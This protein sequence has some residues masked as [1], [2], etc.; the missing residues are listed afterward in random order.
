MRKQKKTL[1]IIYIM[2]FLT[3]NSNFLFFLWIIRYLQCTFI[4]NK[5]LHS[6]FQQNGTSWL[7]ERLNIYFS[8]GMMF[9]SKCNKKK[10]LTLQEKILV[11]K[12]KICNLSF[13]Q[14]WFKFGIIKKDN[15]CPYQEYSNSPCQFCCAQFNIRIQD[16]KHENLLRL[17]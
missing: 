1:I 5:S 4:C 17:P 2:I 7:Y 15:F 9:F 11:N 8:L 10:W 13:N 16:K 14:L 6:T 3:L 12:Q